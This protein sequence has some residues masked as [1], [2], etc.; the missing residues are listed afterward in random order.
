MI[1]LSAKIRKDFSK[2]TK[3]IKKAGKIPAVV[4]GPGVKNFSLQIDYKD[5]QKVFK[6]AGESS[7]VELNIEGEKDKKHVATVYVDK[8]KKVVIEADEPKINEDLL[9]EIYDPEAPNEPPV[10]ILRVPGPQEEEE[11]DIREGTRRSWATAQRPGDPKFLEAL[12]DHLPTGKKK[13]GD[14]YIFWRD[15]IEE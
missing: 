15:I 5:F 4:Y 9:N 12:G 1:S 2:K 8:D 7:L 6:Q 13:Y 14:Y 10:F 11:K 3:S